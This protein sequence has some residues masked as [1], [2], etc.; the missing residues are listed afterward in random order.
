MRKP[1]FYMVFQWLMFLP[2][3]LPLCI[4]FGALQ[5]M[6][7]TVGQ[8]AYQMWEDISV[9]EQSIGTTEL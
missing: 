2:V 8:M 7:N 4:I 3:I 1:N 6:F 5:G 9:V